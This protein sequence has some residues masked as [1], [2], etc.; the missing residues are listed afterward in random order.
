MKKFIV[1]AFVICFVAFNAFAGQS[2]KSKKYMAQQNSQNNRHAQAQHLLAH[3]YVPNHGIFEYY[4]KKYFSAR[5]GKYCSTR[6]A[7][8]FS[9]FHPQ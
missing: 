7:S 8:L 2:T 1:I 9:G 4:I 6:D 3:S 5:V